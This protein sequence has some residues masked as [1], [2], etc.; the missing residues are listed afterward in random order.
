MRAGAGA[1]AWTLATLSSETKVGA[2][3]GVEV[4]ALGISAMTKALLSS[5]AGATSFEAGFFV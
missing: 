3:K 2:G 5:M 1:A 4:S